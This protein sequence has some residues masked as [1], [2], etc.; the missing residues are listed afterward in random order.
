MLKRGGRRVETAAWVSV[1][2]RYLVPR[3]RKRCALLLTFTSSL[4]S[5]IYAQWLNSRPAF[6]SIQEYSPLKCATNFRLPTIVHSCIHKC[7]IASV[8]IQRTSTDTTFKESCAALSARPLLYSAL[9]LHLQSKSSWALLFGSKLYSRRFSGE[10]EENEK[11][12]ASDPSQW[13]SSAALRERRRR[14]RWW[15]AERN[16]AQ[17]SVESQCDAMR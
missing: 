10:R 3:V 6:D 2:Y 8:P 1:Q 9:H 11:W 4:F 5:Y 12:E 17:R 14:G 13:R 16:R 15:R 7:T